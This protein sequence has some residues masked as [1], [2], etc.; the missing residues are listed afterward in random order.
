MSDNA[1][2]VSKSRSK[3]GAKANTI[4]LKPD[5]QELLDGLAKDHG[6]KKGAILAGLR[7]LSDGENAANSRALADAL[8]KLADE[9]EPK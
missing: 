6:G 8:R 4:S 2:R 7:A 1:A 9:I 3:S 5:E